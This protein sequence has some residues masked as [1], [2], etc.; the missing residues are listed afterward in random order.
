[1]LIEF[2][3]NYFSIIIFLFLS[4]GLSLGFI[5]LNFILSPKTPIQKNYLLM[6]VALNPLV[7]LEW[8]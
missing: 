5:V 7:I 4:L 1:M 6:N 3:N 8:N 2:L